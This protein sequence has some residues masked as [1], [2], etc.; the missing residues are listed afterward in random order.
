MKKIAISVFAFAVLSTSLQA[1]SKAPAQSRCNL[2]EATAPNVRGLGLGM[3]AQQ[4]LALFPGLTRKKDLKET[5]ENAKSTSRDDATALGADPAAD[6]DARQFAGVGYAT[7]V[8]YKGR[9][10]EISVEYHG[11][12]W[13]NVD[14]W[15]AKLAEA[16]K[17]PSAASWSVGPSENPN[18][19]LSCSGIMI[20]GAIQGGGSTIRIWNTSYLREI[21]ERARAAEERRRQEVKP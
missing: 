4:F 8:F 7:A 20:E 15:I 17:L 5:I 13:S 16:F 12:T 21:D 6:G 10:V 9:A 11:A 14:E 1:S 18:K 3:T 2:T 19:V